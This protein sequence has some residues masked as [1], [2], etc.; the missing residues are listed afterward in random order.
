MSVH[1][2]CDRCKQWIGDAEPGLDARV[3]IEI[4]GRRYDSCTGTD[5][6]NAFNDF[7]SRVER[8]AQHN[9]NDTRAFVEAEE[10]K[11]WEGGN[12]SGSPQ[13]TADSQ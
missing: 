12:P 2:R 5:C 13:E 6:L 4:N 8:Y 11:F 10:S 3:R 9:V 7:Q 1:Y